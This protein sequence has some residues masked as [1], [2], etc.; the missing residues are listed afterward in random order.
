SVVAVVGDSYSV[1]CVGCLRDCYEAEF[2]RGTVFG[3]LLLRAPTAEWRDIPVRDFCGVAQRLNDANSIGQ[4][5]SL[6][7]RTSQTQRVTV[8]MRNTG[9][10]TSTTGTGYP[11][12]SQNPDDNLGWQCNR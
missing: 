5:V 1:G 4:I 7:M 10:A 11:L 8:L 6:S 2:G 9:T 3:C 12:G